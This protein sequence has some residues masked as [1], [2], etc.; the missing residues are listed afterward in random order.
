MDNGKKRPAINPPYKISPSD[1]AYLRQCGLALEP[2]I[3]RLIELAVEAGW[4]REDVIAA[5]LV[6]TGRHLECNRIGL[7]PRD[8]VCSEERLLESNSAERVRLH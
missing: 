7:D 1:P 3:D 5:I 8:D 2:S 4:V 6:E